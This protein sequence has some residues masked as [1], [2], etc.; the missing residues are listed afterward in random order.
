MIVIAIREAE[1]YGTLKENITFCYAPVHA[2]EN[3]RYLIKCLLQQTVALPK[4]E[5]MP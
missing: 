2:T 4:K 1:A 3:E 5:V